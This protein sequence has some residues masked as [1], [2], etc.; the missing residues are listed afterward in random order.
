MIEYIEDIVFLS[1][2]SNFLLLILAQKI[3]NQRP[4]IAQTFF[5]STVFLVGVFFQIK[6]NFSTFHLV[7]L[8][9]VLSFLMSCIVVENF[10]KKSFFLLSFTLICLHLLIF[11]T[12]EIVEVFVGGSL[13]FFV[14]IFV[15]CLMFSLLSNAT[16][17]FY[18]AK[19]LNSF[20]YNLCL[21]LAEKH[22]NITAY[23]DTGNLLQDDETG[24][25]ILVLNLPTFQ[26]LFGNNATLIDYVTNNLDKK[27]A[28]KYISYSSVSSSA[29]MFVCG[30]DKVSILHKNSREELHLLVGLSGNFCTSDCDA[31]LSPLAL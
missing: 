6:F 20:R 2:L 13:A 31:L 29:K 15:L 10:S 27:I 26:K 8:D 25:P 12:F 17:V 22:I 7:L 23:L 9:A 18:K 19:K 11:A 24:L 30:I 4:K 1:L 16:K 28:G 3:V 5:A 14:K 21:E